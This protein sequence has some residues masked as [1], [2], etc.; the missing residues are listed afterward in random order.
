MKRLALLTVMLI[1]TCLSY[2]TIEEFYTFSE[3]R[4]S[5]HPISGTIV[6]EIST[7]DALSSPIPIGFT[8]PYGDHSYSELKA[9]SNG[10]IG[11]GTSH[12]SSYMNNDLA[13][14]SRVPVLAP[15]WD[16]CNLGTGTCEYL[17]SGTAPD[18]IFTI[19][20]SNQRWGY[21]ASTFFNYQVKLY[22]N[23][24]IEF[25]YG[26]CTGSPSSPSASIGI[27]M[28]PGGSGWFYSITPG[29][30][31]I[32]YTTVANNSVNVF[33]GE[34]VVY[35]FHPVIGIPNDLAALSITGNVIPMIGESYDYTITIRNWGSNS[36]SN[37]E[38]KLLLGTQEIGSLTGPEIQAGE[39]LPLTISWT[40]S[41]TGAGVLYGKVVLVG[42]QNS[43]NDCT[44][45]FNIMVQPQD[46][47][48]VVIGAGNEL[49]HI[50]MDFF[51]K[52]SLYECL[53]YPDELGFASG[54][55]TSLA[56]YN[57]FADSPSNG[58]TRIW[59]GSTTQADLSSGWIPSTQL[60]L[61]FDG[62]ITYPAGINTVIIPFQTP[63]IH[64]SGNLVMMVQRPMDA[65]YYSILDNFY[66]QTVGT[67]RARNHHNSDVDYDPSNPPAAGILSGQ[68]P[69]TAFFYIEQ[70]MEDDMIPSNFIIYLNN[71]LLKLCWDSVPD[72]L[73]Y[74]LYISTTPEGLSIATPVAVYD[75]DL[76]DDIVEVDLDG[77]EPIQFY[78]VTA[79]Y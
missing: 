41:A 17:L 29:D 71:G 13:A 58:A 56:F 3:R 50:P 63:Y 22:E 37:Y 62:N 54:T 70:T 57:N 35:A 25:V 64:T 20:Y 12:T 49:A 7:D 8:F 4:D 42:D 19:Q 61:V 78:R 33:P 47:Q 26:S 24:K 44:P 68:F 59:L 36:Q 34:G 66:V 77:V 52:S 18:R 76:S 14:L 43:N 45:P 5:Y 60:T 31:A 28:L 46:I 11:L 21:A 72:A 39:N 30:P 73:F 55:I 15:L 74:N 65:Q 69:K 40:P 67:N 9:S 48:E 10:C 27:N 1:V 38:V 16:D 6:S 23:G 2:S 51:W 75:S 79:V 53:Y 32:Y